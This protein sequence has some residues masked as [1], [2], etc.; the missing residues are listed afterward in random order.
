M[1]IKKKLKENQTYSASN[2]QKATS[3]ISCTYIP[4]KKTFTFETAI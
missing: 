2:F 4:A 3:H 1:P